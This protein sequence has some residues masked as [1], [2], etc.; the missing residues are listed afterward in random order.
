[1]IRGMVATQEH[2]EITH[3]MLEHAD[4][5]L[6]DGDLIQ[7]SEKGW[8]AVAHYLKAVAKHREWQNRSHRDFFVIKDR[9][10]NETDDPDRISLLFREA[11]ALHQNFYE[12]LYLPSDVKGGIDSAKEFIDRLERAQ[13]LQR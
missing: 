5:C 12:P 7:A 10:A 9:L 3:R 13:V 2:V 11:N 8:G 6:I 1:M 4:E